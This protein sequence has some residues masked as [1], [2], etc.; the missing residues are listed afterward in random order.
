MKYPIQGSCQCGQLRYTL[1]QPPVKV[2][3]CHCTECQKLSSSPYSV[4]AIIDADAI[5]F[6][7]EMSDWSRSSDSGN[8][9]NAKFC[10]GCGNRVYHYNPDNMA[11]LKLKLKPIQMDDDG[12]FE[13]STHLWV[14][15]KLDWVEIP[16]GVT[17]FD[18]QA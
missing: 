7:G 9:N 11:Q 5:E 10:P 18:K 6:D 16:P 8:T 14:S 1:H 4:T 13:P 2:L 12:V 17:V 15:E 3:A